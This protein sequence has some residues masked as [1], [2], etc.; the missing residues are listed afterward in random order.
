MQETN[1]S[2]IQS[3][4]E[5]FGPVVKNQAMSVAANTEKQLKKAADSSASFAEF[6]QKHAQIATQNTN[7]MNKLMRDN[8]SKIRKSRTK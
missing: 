3:I 2:M 6:A 1:G 7:E 4:G 8:T 5:T